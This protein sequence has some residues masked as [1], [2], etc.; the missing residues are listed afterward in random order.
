MERGTT[1]QIEPLLLTEKQAA[2]RLNIS[3]STLRR[4]RRKYA[5]PVLKVGRILRYLDADLDSFI[6]DHHL[7]SA[8]VA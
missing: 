7:S 3:V 2:Q 6:A 1:L 4:W 8:E 5:I